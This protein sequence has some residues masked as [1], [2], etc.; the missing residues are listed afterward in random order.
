MRK[1]KII[2]LIVLNVTIA[3]LNVILFSPG[4]VGLRFEGES[5]FKTALAATVILM[6]MIIF[7]VG[8]YKIVREAEKKIKVDEIDSVMDYIDALEQNRTKKTF[9]KDIGILLEQIEKLEKKKD[10][11][12]EL[13]LDKFTS[14]EMSYSKFEGVIISIQ[15]IF[16]MNIKSILN[17]LNIFD[18]EDYDQMR[19]ENAKEKFSTDFIQT[20]LSIYNQYIAFV[21]DSVE[22]NEQIL[23]KLDQLLL[24]ISKFNSLEDGE[25]ENMHAMQEIDELISK[26][27]FYK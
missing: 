8:N 13:L 27:K 10:T 19:R 20:K 26:A 4:L 24:E 9:A 15:K 3:V 25:L 11:I 2:K 18:Q 6:S 1:E 23:L 5:I 12:K 22:D 7:V 17:K 16:Y 14:S 21:R